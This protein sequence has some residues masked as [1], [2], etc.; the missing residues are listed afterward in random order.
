MV[1][2]HYRIHLVNGQV[3]RAAE[4]RTEEQKDL[5]DRYREALPTGTLQIGLDAPP[6]AIIP[7]ANILYVSRVRDEFRS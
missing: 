6:T 5:L 2:T 4:R 3:I 7:V 1:I